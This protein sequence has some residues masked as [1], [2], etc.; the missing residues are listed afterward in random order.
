[1]VKRI[2]EA[3]EKIERN[4]FENALI[5]IS[6][7]IDIAAKNKYP[8]LTGSGKV[9]ERCTKLIEEY[10]DFI[11][12]FSTLGAISLAGNIKYGGKFKGKTL[13]EILYKVIRCGLLHD[14]KLEHE[15]SFVFVKGFGIGGVRTSI[16]N[17]KIKPGFV[18]SN[19]LLLGLCLVL[20]ENDDSYDYKELNGF[21]EFVIGEKS[22]T[23][24]KNIWLEE[25]LTDKILKKFE[26]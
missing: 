11:Y 4:D 5:Q 23:I 21:K 19:G 18:I 17:T 26:I 22:I 10:R 7:G 9:G 16:E 8:S 3:L 15:E 1:M 14:G 24:D 13:G 6:I 12:R 25:N 20:I 2:I